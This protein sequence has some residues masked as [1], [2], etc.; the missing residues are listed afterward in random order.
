MLAMFIYWQVI[1]I[2]M[3][4]SGLSLDLRRLLIY[5]I[6]RVQL[7]GIEVILRV[8]MAVEMAIIT[9]GLAIGLALNPAI[10]LWALLG[11]AAF[12]ALNL[13][14][15]AGLRDLFTRLM[16]RKGVREGAILAVVL[17]AASPQLFL[18]TTDTESLRHSIS[19]GFGSYWPWTS[20]AAIA[21]GR[22]DAFSIGVLLA[23]TVGAY[24]FSR[25]QF[26]RT[27]HA[28]LAEGSATA[29]R[30]RRV[31]YLLDV[32]ARVPGSLLRDPLA[33][34]VEK[35]VRTLGRAPRFR[36]LFLMGFSFGLLI[37]LPMAMRAEPNSPVA[38][39]YLTIV[40]AYALMLLGEVCF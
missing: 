36:L 18:S 15:S 12:S 26:E 4:S 14:L 6:P 23:W 13:F 27:I 20:T 17:L 37:W 22:P 16:A 5:P 19:T 8:T 38:R 31:P 2:A 1:P 35:E 7:F 34:L 32:V 25:W 24:A 39:N 9:A 29:V 40:S 28:D 33:A 3:A 11:L 10:P 30:A 21:I